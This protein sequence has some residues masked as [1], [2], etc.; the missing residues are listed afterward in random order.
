MATHIP[1]M[2]SSENGIN[3]F[4]LGG[5]GSCFSLCLGL[6]NCYF[7]WTFPLVAIV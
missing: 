5:V 3:A 4:T 6:G 1:K 2:K 7:V